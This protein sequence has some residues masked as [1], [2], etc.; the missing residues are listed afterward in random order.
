ML[1]V[2]P[3]ATDTQY[4]QVREL[5]EEYIQWDASQLTRLGLSAREALDFSEHHVS[6]D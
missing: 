4:R 1:S 6:T 2:V 3:A 5:L